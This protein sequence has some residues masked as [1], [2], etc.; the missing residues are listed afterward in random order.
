[1]K[2]SKLEIV[3]Q[4]YH[5]T[6]LFLIFHFLRFLPRMTQSLTVT[7]ERKVTDHK[8][9]WW[10]PSDR[11]K[12]GRSSCQLH[13]KLNVAGRGLNVIFVLKH[14]Q[15][16]LI[17]P[18]ICIGWV[19]KTWRHRRSWVEDRHRQLNS[20]QWGP[21]LNQYWIKI[22]CCSFSLR[23]YDKFRYKM[24]IFSGWRWKFYSTSL[25][26]ETSQTKGTDD[27]GVEKV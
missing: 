16:S 17:S 22:K 13:W 20:C 2:N 27:S 3:W 15:E 5:K 23:K 6:R 14:I 25:R 9:R 19:W 24:S 26:S 11:R 4:R 10:C 21:H 18:C 12:V 8:E 1:M 7:N